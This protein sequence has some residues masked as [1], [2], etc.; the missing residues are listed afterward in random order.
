MNDF[1]LRGGFASI[2]SPLQSG[3]D[4]RR[5]IVSGGI[6]FQ[7]KAWAFDFGLSRE[8]TSDVYVP[9]TV[10]GVESN[11]ASSKLKNTRIMLTLTTKF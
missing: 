7:E 6:G 2:G 5:N 8:M 11:V 3:E 1:R 9:F 4:F 10:R